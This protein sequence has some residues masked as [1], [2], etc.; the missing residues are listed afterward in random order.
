MAQFVLPVKILLQHCD[1]A[2]IV[3][4]PRF[5]EMANLVVERWFEDE[6]G[7]SF[8]DMIMRDRMGVPTAAISAQFKAPSRLGDELAF[9]LG[10]TR[11]GRTSAGLS[12]VGACGGERAGLRGVSGRRAG[13]GTH[14]ACAEAADRGF[15][16]LRDRA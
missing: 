5:F 2:G 6:L 11:L 10:L 14:A 3:Y 9:Q 1:T 13:G 12:I 8:A 16:V 4:Y 7:Y 15:A